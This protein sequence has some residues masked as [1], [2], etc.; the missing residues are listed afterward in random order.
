M[1][2]VDGTIGTSETKCSPPRIDP[3][4]RGDGPIKDARNCLHFIS[5]I[6]I[7]DY[8]LRVVG[9]TCG[10]NKSSA[11]QA[12]QRLTATKKELSIRC[13]A[14]CVDWLGML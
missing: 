10:M 9:C 14:K 7:P 1:V 8:E 4:C 3:R 12:R 6:Q 11:L 2:Y 13:D 5:R